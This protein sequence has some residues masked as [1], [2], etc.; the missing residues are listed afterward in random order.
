MPITGSKDTDFFLVSIKRNNKQIS[1][2][3]FSGSDDVILKTIDLPQLLLPLTK[4]K[5]K[6]LHF[7]KSKPQNFLLLLWV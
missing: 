2:N 6:N 3:F 4:Y 7:F 5:H 1:F